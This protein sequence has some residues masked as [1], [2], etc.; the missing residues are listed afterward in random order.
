MEKRIKKERGKREKTKN[1]L[2]IKKVWRSDNPMSHTSK[3]AIAS[4][5]NV[6]E[7]ELQPR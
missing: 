6:T 5:R 1:K 7:L 4:R 3:C 2:K